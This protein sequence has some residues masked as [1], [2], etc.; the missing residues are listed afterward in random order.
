[1][2]IIIKYQS[3][4]GLCGITICVKLIFNSSI[5]YFLKLFSNLIILWEEVGITKFLN[6]RS[7]SFVLIVFL[8]GRLMIVWGSWSEVHLEN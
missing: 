3:I 6:F 5:Y 1:M 2:I 4:I 8:F 7:F